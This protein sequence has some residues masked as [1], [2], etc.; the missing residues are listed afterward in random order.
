MGVLRRSWKTIWSTPLGDLDQQ[1]RLAE[2]K[3]FESTAQIDQESPFSHLLN[4]PRRHGPPDQ[5][6]TIIGP[7]KL[8]EKIGEGGM[9]VVY[10]ADQIE[11]VK[12]RLAT[13][14]SSNL[15]WTLSK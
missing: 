14:R 9:G 11:P 10:M 7:Y 15:V 4:C 3:F 8:L 13:R 5:S 6:G 2:G 1:I 12:R